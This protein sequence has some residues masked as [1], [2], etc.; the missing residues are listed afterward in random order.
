MIHCNMRSNTKCN[1]VQYNVMEC[2]VSGQCVGRW[3]LVAARVS[4]VCFKHKHCTALCFEC[5]SRV[6]RVESVFRQE[7]SQALLTSSC[8]SI[9]PIGSQPTIPL[10]FSVI[11]V[12]SSKIKFQISWGG[13]SDRLL[14]QWS[15]LQ[16]QLVLVA[17]CQSLIISNQGFQALLI[18]HFGRTA[19]WSDIRAWLI[20]WL[21]LG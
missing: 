8:S 21:T 9:K 3:R 1:G 13:V 5:V 12:S 19:P 14:N 2:L 20:K 15:E 17:N 10:T 6:S 7:A 16:Q 11:N 18:S 4:R